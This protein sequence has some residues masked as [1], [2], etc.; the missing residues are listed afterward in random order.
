MFHEILFQTKFYSQEIYTEGSRLM[1]ISLLRFKKKSLLWAIFISLV[2]FFDY[3]CPIRLMRILA[4][5]NFP[6][7]KVALG[8]IPLQ[9]ISSALQKITLY[10][11]K[12]VLKSEIIC[13]LFKQCYQM[14]YFAKEQKKTFLLYKILE[15]ITVKKFLFPQ[16]FV[17]TV[18]F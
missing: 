7:P 15:V 10:V 4:N 1:Q 2:Q 5:V 13:L 9:P 3:F 8:K 16:K 14:Q 11:D 6:E 17:N 18:F 12:F